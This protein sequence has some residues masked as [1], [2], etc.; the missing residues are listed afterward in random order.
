M[1]QY[2]RMEKGLL[3]DPEDP[4]IMREQLPFQDRLWEFNRLKPSD[5]FLIMLLQS[6]THAV[7][8]TKYRREIG[9]I[10][11]NKNALTGKICKIQFLKYYG[12]SKTVC[13]RDIFSW[14]GTDHTI[15]VSRDYLNSYELK[16]DKDEKW[17]HWKA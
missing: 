10:F 13:N 3:Y 1:T 9:S 5:L 17:V 2:E 6:V 4:E 14:N 12:C 15:Y 11:I 8:C 7:S 16:K